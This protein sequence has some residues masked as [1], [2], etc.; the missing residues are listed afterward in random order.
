MKILSL[1]YLSVLIFLL[2]FLPAGKTQ[3]AGT[4]PEQD[5][6]LVVLVTWADA[7]GTPATNVYVEARGFVPRYNAQKSFVLNSS[8]AGRYEASLPP[9]VYDVFVSDSISVPSCKRVLITAGSTT[10]WALQPQLD[11]VYSEK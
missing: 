1:R 11:E 3:D 5:G 10:S 2:A 6:K 8:L 9:G 4:R 7:Y